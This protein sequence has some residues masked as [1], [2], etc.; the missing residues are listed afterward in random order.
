MIKPGHYLYIA[1]MMR[2]IYSVKSNFASVVDGTVDTDNIYLVSSYQGLPLT[3]GSA[4]IVPQISHNYKDISQN[5]AFRIID[6]GTWTSKQI[7]DYPEIYKQQSYGLYPYLYHASII[8]FESKGELKFCVSFPV[9]QKVH[10]YNTNFTLEESHYMQSNEIDE[11]PAFSDLYYVAD[12]PDQADHTRYYNSLSYYTGLYYDGKNEIFYRLAKIHVPE[13]DGWPFKYSVVAFDKE[14]KAI[15]EST[16]PD[17]YKPSSAFGSKFGL[18]MLNRKK[19]A[20][21]RSAAIPYAI[22]SMQ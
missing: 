15:G 12:Q 4:S 10:I 2:S 22:L 19:F 6:H 1:N 17:D 21:D 8:H 5:K 7:I 16:V 9:D 20:N 13:K 3:I 14:F 11:I 18:M